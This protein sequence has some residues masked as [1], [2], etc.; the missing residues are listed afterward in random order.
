MHGVNVV[1]QQTAV[2]TAEPPVPKPSGSEAGMASGN[3]KRY[4]PPVNVETDLFY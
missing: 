3:K 2:Y 1:R 4:K